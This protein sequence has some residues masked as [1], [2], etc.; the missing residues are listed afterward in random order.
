MAKKSKVLQIDKG[1]DNI[2]SGML[3]R[4]IGLYGI[5]IAVS[6]FIFTQDSAEVKITL[7]FIAVIGAFALWLNNLICLGRNI[8][9]IRNL[10]LFLPF[11]LYFIFAAGNFFAHPYITARLGALFQFSACSCLFVIAAF[12]FDYKKTPKLFSYI[13]AAAWIVCSYGLLQIA[14][15]YIISG[16]DILSWTGFFHERIF[17][18]IA[19]PN[20]LAD[21]CVFTFFIA[22]G[23]FLNSRSKSTLILMFLILLN[24][25]FT[26]SKGAWLALGAGVFIFGIIYFNFF[27]ENY[28]QK[29]FK[30]NLIIAG[31]LVCAVLAAGIFT[32]K[33]KQSVDFRLSTWRSSF[34]MVQATPAFGMGLGSFKYIYTA[35][36]RPEIFYMEGLHNA[37]TQHAENYPLEQ[38]CEHGLLGLGIWLLVLF[39]QAAGFLKKLKYFEAGSKENR[40]D[41]LLLLVC[42]CACAVIYIHNLVDI[43]I[44]FVSTAYFLALS[45]GILFALNF[46]PLD[47]ENI[48][49]IKSVCL[50]T[51]DKICGTK[52]FYP[53]FKICFTVFIFL[54]VV[55]VFVF[56]RDFKE[57]CIPALKGKIHFFILFWFSFLL[58]VSYTVITFIKEAFFSRRLITL[59]IFCIASGLMY[60][61]FLP[62]RAGFYTAAAIGLSERGNP[63]AP[64]Y[65][66]KAIKTAPLSVGLYQFSA[67]TFQNRG[68][69]IKTNHPQEGDNADSVYNDYERALW[70]Y[71]KS[72]SFIPNA[73]LIHYNLGS[74]YHDMAK[75]AAAKQDFKTAEEN[76]KLAQQ[77]LK[78]SLLLDPVFDNT[79]YQLANIALAHKD[80]RRA[81]NWVQL[82]IDGPEE[83]SNPLYIA[84]HRNDTKALLNLKNIKL[85][86]GL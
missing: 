35:Y 70:R 82:Y 25:I 14:D 15:R 45:N 73:P 85:L 2:S 63:A 19:N 68:E 75:E 83:V 54:L 58:I 34:E 32:A 53:Y 29:H 31:I 71:K 74:L 84:K 46:G 77:A 47:Q 51:P 79:Y 64:V 40:K 6:L 61:A 38:T 65:Y 4:W 66:Q 69:K 56:F 41:K 39:W 67:I 43:S 8:F 22:L 11:I 16:I 24:I 55:L 60:L 78:K 17:S 27:S 42:F 18:T 80:Y 37:E 36:K 5:F 76:Y 12:Y 13:L 49:N 62:F 23:S 59:I 86:G 72:L 1:Q 81:A 52:K 9:T 3:I 33:R 50:K 44:Y 48:T 20:F 7:F 30:Y 21:F 28:K 57:M 26:L 10:T